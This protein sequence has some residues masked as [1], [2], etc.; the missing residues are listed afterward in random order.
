MRPAQHSL[1]VW[2]LEQLHGLDRKIVVTLVGSLLL[3]LWCFV[4]F[5]SWW[6]RSSILAT[7][8]RVLQQ[9]TIAVHEQT[10]GLFRQAETAL[11]VA[12]HWMAENPGKDPGTSAGF[13]TLIDRLRQTS[14]GVI[15]IRLV[16]RDGILRYVP[17][18]GQARRT[19]VSDR[20]YFRAQ[21]DLSTRGLYVARP[22]VSRVTG[23]WGIP[24]SLP[25]TRAGGEVAV[26]FAAIELDRIAA[27]FEAERV[28]PRGTIVILRED[29]TLMFRSPL[30][31]QAISTAIAQRQDWS[32]RLVT[33]PDGLYRIES[34]PADGRE[35]IVSLQRVED[36]PL[37]V[38][39]T[40][41]AGDLLADW[42]RDTSVLV[43]VATFLSAAIVLLGM[44]L[45]RSMQLE[46][47][48]RRELEQRMLTDPLTGTGNRRMLELRL[49]EEIQ[50]ARRY[51]RA[52]TAVFLDLDHF[53]QVN[54]R[55]GHGV[56]DAV[57]VRVAESLHARLRHSDHLARFGGEEFVLLL[58]ET[59]LDAAL[60][61]VER[62]R[63]AVAE[64]RIPELQPGH[65]TL[66][67]GLAQWQPGE[68]ADALLHRADQALYRA[69]AAGRNRAH[70]DRPA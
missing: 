33:S 62:M 24:I 8:A 27:S 41:D 56:G 37:V 17:D 40:A 39:V 30:D 11:A 63:T 22:V 44:R 69:K 36:Y 43:L 52:L 48:A 14:D 28:K 35:Q 10:R 12:S 59:G 2:F 5:W 38:A 31:E 64:L 57:L 25:V 21:A 34:S 9:L 61:L 65:I 66:S 55:H 45:L 58:P 1:R 68:S 15:D 60:A 32:Q 19:D 4:G 50:R 18:Q 20:D 49:A 42:Q 70:V 6:E 26:V 3:S 7:N 53:K 51:E 54:D 16:S 67:A 23:K 13:V 47:A 29:G 46:A